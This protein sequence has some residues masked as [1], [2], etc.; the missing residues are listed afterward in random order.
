MQLFE[1]TNEFFSDAVNAIYPF[2]SCVLLKWDTSFRTCTIWIDIW[3]KILTF[4]ECTG[5]VAFTY[6]NFLTCWV[7]FVLFISYGEWRLENLETFTRLLTAPFSNNKNFICWLEISWYCCC[8]IGIKFTTK[9]ILS[10]FRETWK[11]FEHAGITFL[12][13]YNP[14]AYTE[15]IRYTWW[16]WVYYPLV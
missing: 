10:D 2:R 15:P 13:P 16:P 3:K 4:K 14:E 9:R 5:V 1:K 11:K 8:Q 12:N 6:I 7:I